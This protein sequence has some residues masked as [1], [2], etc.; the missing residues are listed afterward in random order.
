MLKLIERVKQWL[1]GKYTVAPLAMTV[2]LFATGILFWGGFNWAMELT[3]N[4]PF[5]IS[6]HEMRENVYREYRQS[7]HYSNGSGVRATCP[8]CHVPREWT[9]KVIRKVGATNE[10][11][12]KML[13]SID[14]REKFLAK[15]ME[16][17]EHVWAAMYANDSLECRNCHEL[18]SMAS[19]EQSAFASRAHQK[20]QQQAMT[21]I[22]CHKGVA[23]SL[24]EEFLDAEH[25]RYEREE[26]SCDNCHEGLRHEA[27]WGDDEW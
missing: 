18:E 1:I 21:C 27:D 26:V 5:C 4:E 24:P 3:N 19:R 12:H 13:G 16:L 20:A 11:F 25:E 15:R 23:H 6:C 7:A 22:D 8:D 2:V 10:L 14:T 17:A 9:D